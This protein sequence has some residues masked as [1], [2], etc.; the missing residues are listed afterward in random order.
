METYG[1]IDLDKDPCIF[2]DCGHIATWSTMDGQMGLKDF[3][4]ISE[5]GL[6]MAILD[7]PHIFNPSAAIKVCP[8]CRGSLRNIARYGRLVRR[9][10]LD[11][12]TRKFITWAHN[13]WQ[14]M[15]LSLTKIQKRPGLQSRHLQQIHPESG[16]SFDLTGTRDDQVNKALERTAI[17]REIA[18]FRSRIVEYSR[19]VSK[20]EQPYDR[21]A[22]LV[23][24]ANHRHGTK[25][26]FVYDETVIQ[27]GKYIEA[28]ATSLECD[29]RIISRYLTLCRG[30]DQD[31][32]KSAKIDLAP[33]IQDCE[34]LIKEASAIHQ[35]R[36]MVR[37][38]LFA[39]AFC[40]VATESHN[41]TSPSSAPQEMEG[42]KWR[43]AGLVH[44]FMAKQIMDDHP[45]TA[46]FMSYFNKL[47]KVLN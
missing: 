29:L 23:R 28:C 42:Q 16:E 34:Q 11:E 41:S 13:E 44:L 37:V 46:G 3:Y 26:R 32:A 40:A 38:H 25:N 27:M 30:S 24:H 20:Q 15:S 33:Y 2:P 43:K 22:Q 45:S 39:S 6:P 35:H 12:S 36:Q 14:S 1:C 21:V 7:E 8:S 4:T 5:E 9:G 18:R 17:P 31:G 47:W 10:I 19:H